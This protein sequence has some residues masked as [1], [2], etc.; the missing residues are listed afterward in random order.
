MKT[1]PANFC[2]PQRCKP[3]GQGSYLLEEF[4]FSTFLPPLCLPQSSAQPTLASR[5]CRY[6]LSPSFTLL[7]CS[8]V[9]KVASILQGSQL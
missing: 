1:R 3:L 9:A 8:L 4:L 7:L 5:G 2:I 6:V